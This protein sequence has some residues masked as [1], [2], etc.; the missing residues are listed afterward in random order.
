M[1]SIKN[2]QIKIVI[3]TLFFIAALFPITE[4]I[5][6]N[7]IEEN[8]DVIDQSQEWCDNCRYISNYEW[9]EF[10]PT[11]ITHV[12]IEVKIAQWYGGS[13]NLKL[14][15]EKPLGTI[16]S[17]KELP[18][19]ALPSGSCDWVSFDIPNINLNPGQSYYIKLTAPLGSEYG[20][21]LSNSNLYPSGDSSQHPGDWCFRI[22]CIANN[23]PN[24]P[25]TSYDRTNDILVISGTDPDG[26]MIR[27]GISWNYDTTVDQ[28]TSL[29]PSG[30]T[31]SIA[32]SGRTGSVKIIS[33]DE[34]GA[35][36][37]WVSQNCKTKSL[38]MHLLFER[39]VQRDITVI[40]YL[41]NLW[42]F[43]I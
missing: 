29:V 10:I 21:C 22:Y 18:A 15:I 40:S 25:S 19:N 32:C 17:T 9:Q 28:W 3:V 2:K 7:N 38:M 14:T 39:F 24:I 4:N 5:K 8:N 11:M 35:Q 16:L 27:Y 31:Q 33:E 13:P 6:A 43:Y 12:R 36:S 1:K 42:L 20:W 23:A 34:Y 30:T 41:K 26:D 37:A